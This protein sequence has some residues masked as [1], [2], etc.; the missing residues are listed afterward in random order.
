MSKEQ[1]FR[2]YERE[3]NNRLA[4]AEDLT[5]PKCSGYTVDPHPGPHSEF[6]LY[7]KKESESK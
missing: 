4:A 2:E 5:E 7:F 6:C 3:Y 1:W